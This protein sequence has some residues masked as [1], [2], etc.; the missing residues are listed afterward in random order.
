M[1]CMKPP[2]AVAPALT[3]RQRQVAKLRSTGFTY[4]EIG[5]R[6]GI[7]EERVREIEMRLRRRARLN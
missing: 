1:R 4:A 3:E 6:L 5:R 2:N 7:S